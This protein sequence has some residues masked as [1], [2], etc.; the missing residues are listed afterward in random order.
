MSMNLGAK[1]RRDVKNNSNG[2]NYKFLLYYI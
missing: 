1:A 2:N